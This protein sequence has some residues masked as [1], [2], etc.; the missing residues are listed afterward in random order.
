MLE[1]D[2]LVEEQEDLVEVVD[3]WVMVCSVDQHL[4][5][6]N[7]VLKKQ[8]VAEYEEHGES[9]VRRLMMLEVFL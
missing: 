7:R 9:S 6:S 5:D 4:A 1:V 2:S 3:T 8:P